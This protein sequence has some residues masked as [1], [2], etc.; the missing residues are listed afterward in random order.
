MFSV[1][2]MFS[3]VYSTTCLFTEDISIFSVKSDGNL[4]FCV[5]VIIFLLLILDEIRI[6]LQPYDE[7]LQ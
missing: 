6:L 7:A 3:H 1:Y 5:V 4:I 2:K